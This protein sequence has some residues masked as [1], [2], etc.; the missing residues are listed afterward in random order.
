MF[1]KPEIWPWNFFDSC[2][3]KRA[4]FPRS[5]SY[6]PAAAKDWWPPL[7]AANKISTSGYITRVVNVYP[8]FLRQTVRVLF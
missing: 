4:E 1:S 3:H 7:V 8:A 5:L 2:L 6:L